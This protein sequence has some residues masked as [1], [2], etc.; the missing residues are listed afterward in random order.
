MCEYLRIPYTGQTLVDLAYRSED[1]IIN[2]EFIT[3]NG[4]F[5]I[6]LSLCTLDD[7]W[8]GAAAL[9]PVLEYLHDKLT[10]A[11]YDNLPDMLHPSVESGGNLRVIGDEIMAEGF[12][13]RIDW[14]WTKTPCHNPKRSFTDYLSRRKRSRVNIEFVEPQ[15]LSS[16]NR[17]LRYF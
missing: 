5:S 3:L 17:F 12:Y 13:Y 10:Q 8:K 2:S 7:R 14:I 1:I 15:V 4:E 9:T 11:E 16:F 6:D